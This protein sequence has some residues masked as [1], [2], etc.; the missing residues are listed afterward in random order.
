MAATWVVAVPCGRHGCTGLGPGCLLPR[1][2]WQQGYLP[3]F[4]GGC[5]DQ[6]L[7]QMTEQMADDFLCFGD[8]CVANLV[9]CPS[10][11][12]RGRQLPPA[13]GA[14]SRGGAM[15]PLL[16]LLLLLLLVRCG[17]DSEQEPSSA[18]AAELRE[19]YGRYTPQRLDRV[20]TVLFRYKG[21]E[22]EIM[23]DVREKFR[24]E[25]A[26]VALVWAVDTLPAAIVRKEALLDGLEWLADNGLACAAAALAALGLVAVWRRARGGQAKDG[27]PESEP[28]KLRAERR[29]VVTVELLNPGPLSSL[30]VPV[31]AFLGGI[32]CTVIACVLLRDSDM[33]AE[34]LM[35][36]GL[37]TMN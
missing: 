27:S 29:K 32:I 2:D 12:M 3:F 37:A 35:E 10:N 31:S 22:E 5:F 25:P 26:L 11:A 9:E 30:W 13:V 6:T 14:Q 36:R 19:W 8:M 4:D 34:M 23:P 16:S 24:S 17:A 7:E 18:A 33:L 21:R 28:T 1:A 20:D 15:L